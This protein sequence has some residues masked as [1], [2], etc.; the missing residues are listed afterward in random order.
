M[1]VFS[2]NMTGGLLPKIQSQKW[3]DLLRRILQGRH[4][5][6]TNGEE[7][8]SYKLWTIVRA[9]GEFVEVEVGTKV[10]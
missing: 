3:L 5:Y 8:L 9:V 1:T 7:C 2:R 4:G 10:A 6:T